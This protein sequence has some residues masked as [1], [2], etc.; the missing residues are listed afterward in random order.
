[1]TFSSLVGRTFATTKQGPRY[2]KRPERLIVHHCANTNSE[3]MVRYLSGSGGGTS[4]TYCLTTGPELVGIVPEE[5]RPW[6]SNAVV[7]G[8][9]YDNDSNSVTVETVNLTG[10]P[11]WR[12]TDAQI[13]MLA[14]LAADLCKRYGWGKLDR[15]RVVGH[16][17]V[18]PNGYTECPGPYLYAHL[19]WIVERG[20]QIIAGRRPQQRR[21]SMSTLYVLEGSKPSLFALAGDGMG[22]AAWLETEDYN[23][24][25]QW[26]KVHH[27][28]PGISA[29]PLSSGTWNGF[30]Q[31]YKTGKLSA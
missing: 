20:N 13:E 3:A 17:E 16:R 7:G 2:G 14:Q 12:V 22:E 31:R 27:G 5:L 8:V 6:T 28:D 29:I 10:A 23:L 9:N 1:M 26:R 21:R 15:R 25:V 4:A 30:K 18:L 19:D 24:A 11:E